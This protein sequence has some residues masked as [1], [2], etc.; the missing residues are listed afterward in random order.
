METS[1]K[2]R[3]IILS[4]TGILLTGLICLFISRNI[5]LC[6]IVDKRTTRIE[7]AYG[8]QIHYQK[9]QMEGCNKV[10]LQGLSIIPNQRD[11]LLTLQSVNVKLSFW[12]LLKGEVE[13]RNVHMDGLAINF[14]KYDSLANYDFLFLKRQQETESKPAIES[15]YANR[16]DRVLN[17][18]YGFLPENGQL[19]QIKIAERKDS[20][21]VAVNIPS[22]VIKDNHFQSTIQIKEDTLPQQQW[23]A[24]GEL[25]R[26]DYTLKAALFA[27]EKKKISL[28]Y[29]T[30]RFG[31]EV[32]FDTL[33]YSMTK[34]KRAT[35]QL[36][37]KGK[38]RVNGLDVFHKAF[39]PEIIHLDRGQ[40]CY[41]M[42]INGHSFE[43]DSTTIVDFNKLQFHPYLRA[44]KEKGNWHFTAAVNK[45]WFPADDLFSSLPKGLFSNL[46][47]IKTSGELAYHFLLDIDFARLDSIKFESEL[48]EKDF[49]IIE[50]GAT[51]LSKMSEEFVYTA[52]ENG[53]PVKTFPVGPSWEHF[54][55]LD[56]ISPLLRMSV[57]QSEDG[58]FFYHKGFLPDA[59]REALIYDLQVERF[60]RGGSTITMQ[61]VKNV[62]L[63]RNKN[64]ARKLEE[65]LIV[66][67][68]ETE[69]LTS[70]ERM[71]E[72]YLNIA[73]WGPLVYGIQEASAYY[74]GKRPSQL[75]TEESIFLA[76]II[77]KP[78]H[79][80][81][82]FAENGRL[83]ENMEGYYKLIAGRLAKKGLISEIEADSIR[84]DIQVTGDALNSLVGETPESSSPTAEEQ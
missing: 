45:S 51:S 8:L 55:P 14:I 6:H 13:V 20:N 69:R 58:A 33:S 46:E 66:W 63:N 83:K 54:T 30:R 27:P 28:P 44:E 32:T 15:N 57:M 16:I 62:F 79:F 3:I 70:K 36:L 56:S 29:I 37:L 68:I 25:N 48:K 12:K 47:G 19:N 73:E 7:Q 2:K 34:D 21:F 52:Y 78:K 11:T 23:Q 9:L 59:M 65:A 22:F 5:I 75:T 49:R 17:L 76:S 31:A 18:I 84:P 67:L 74:F 35:A 1:S 60:A 82:S 40:L 38:A 4:A 26:R 50:Y 39:S 71:Y 24:S 77:P 41:E 43:L 61:L 72:V 10:V 53:I 81:S 42:N 80:R 64:F